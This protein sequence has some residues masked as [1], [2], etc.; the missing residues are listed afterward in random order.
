ML[1]A[2]LAIAVALAAFSWRKIAEFNWAAF[3]SVYTHIHWGWMSLAA[4]LSFGTYVTRV[5]RWEVMIRHLKPEVSKA[6][7]LRDTIIGFTAGVI[8]GRPG[9]LVRPF[10]I[11]RSEGLTFS[12]QM[13]AWVLERIF[14]LLAVI[15]LF[16]WALLQFD[17]ESRPIGPAIG[18]ILRVG[19][20]GIAIIGTAC[21]TV[22]FLA[23]RFHELFAHRLS[24]ALSFLPERFQKKITELI[25]AFTSGMASCRRTS[26]VLL[27]FGYTAIEWLIITGSC[28]CFFKAFPQTASMSVLDTVLFIGFVSF[29]SLAQIPGIGGGTQIA[30]TVVLT[31][32]FSHTTETAAGIALANWLV[33]W[34]SILPV[35]LVLA[36][37]QGLRWSSLREISRDLQRQNEAPKP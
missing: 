14:D 27:L 29:G 30:G 34:V 12:S 6:R 15:L 5:Y 9:E 36:A 37:T 19:G 23:G 11:A 10:L 25:L 28:A 32:L 21:L 20:A 4:F 3:G 16:G 22:L 33:M 1:L 8:L 24:D 18:W 2:V 7:M 26:E 17:P 31:Q 13:A 35:G